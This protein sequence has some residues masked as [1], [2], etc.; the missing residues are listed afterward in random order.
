MGEANYQ[1]KIRFP[2]GT[3]KKKLPKIK[4][5]FVKG[6]EAY[7]YWQSNRTKPREFFRKEF[8]KKFP[9]I[10]DYI[11]TI[12]NIW[13]KGLSGRLSFANSKADVED[14]TYNKTSLGDEL[15]F[16]SIVWHFAEW[17]PLV[18]YVQKKFGGIKNTW[19]SDEYVP[20]FTIED[21]EQIV[22]DILNKAPLPTL[23]GINKELDELISYR[24]KNS[25]NK[26]EKK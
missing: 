14:M 6:C 11:N 8:E 13:Y 20:P 10:S 19:T 24:L 16:E 21:N 1:M 22:N 3:L 18:N 26:K 4:A 25:P 9:Q 7:D 2:A 12:P 23:M 5:F 15:F 17:T